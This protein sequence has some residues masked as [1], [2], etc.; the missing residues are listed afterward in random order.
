VRAAERAASRLLGRAVRATGF[1]A[2]CDMTYL[3]NGAGIPSII[4]GPDSIEVAHQAN[5]CIS[6]DQMA[7]AVTLYLDTLRIW[8]ENGKSF[9]PEKP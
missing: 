2:T 8:A 4:L 5:E 6:I 9:S 3:V 7:Q 1:T